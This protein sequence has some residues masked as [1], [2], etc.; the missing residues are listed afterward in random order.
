VI[1]NIDKK[2]DRNRRFTVKQ[3]KIV[4]DSKLDYLSSTKTNISYKP[5][6]KNI[7]VVRF[8]CFVSSLFLVKRMRGLRYILDETAPV[9]SN[10][11][12]CFS[13]I[14]YILSN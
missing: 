11:Y 12:P 6:P 10:Q 5:F 7:S 14:L 13:L 8:S 2:V 9:R 3:V 1:S 4:F